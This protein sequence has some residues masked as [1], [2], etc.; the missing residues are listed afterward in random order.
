MGIEFPADSM[1][2]EELIDKLATS[3]GLGC[4]SP[5]AVSASKVPFGIV[6]RAR[7]RDGCSLGGPEPS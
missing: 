5:G 7:F 3:S 6:M 1:R 2:L 4:D